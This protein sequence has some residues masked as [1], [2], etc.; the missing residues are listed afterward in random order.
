MVSSGVF[1]NFLVDIHGKNQKAVY[2]KSNFL[3]EMAMLISSYFLHFEMYVSTH[4]HKERYICMY[5]HK[6]ILKL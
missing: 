2:Q 3:A 4:T 1:K 6:K 5:I